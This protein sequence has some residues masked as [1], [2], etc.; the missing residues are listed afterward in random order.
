MAVEVATG[1]INLSGSPGSVIVYTL[2]MDVTY[3]LPPKMV[4][5]AVYTA[6]GTLQ[7]SSDGNTWQDV[8]L[9]ANNEVNV[10][11]K[12]IQCIDDDA[13]VSVKELRKR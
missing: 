7:V 9:D 11:S 13:T 3:P 10:S 1:S 12:F 8:T 5:I 6:T 4:R 2:E